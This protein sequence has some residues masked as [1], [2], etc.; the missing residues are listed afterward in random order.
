MERVRVLIYFLKN[1]TTVV[2]ERK[3]GKTEKKILFK[4]NKLIC[5]YS[6]FTSVFSVVNMIP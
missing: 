6:F 3:M 1:L 4:S 5:A 2:T